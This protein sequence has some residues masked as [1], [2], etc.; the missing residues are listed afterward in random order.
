LVDGIESGAEGVEIGFSFEV[1]LAA[2]L[3]TSQDDVI[4]TIVDRFTEKGRDLFWPRKR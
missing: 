1:Q 2:W 3:G 4:Q